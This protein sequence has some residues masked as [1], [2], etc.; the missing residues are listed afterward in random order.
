MLTEELLNMRMGKFTAS[1]S[2]ILFVGGKGATR[3]N[4]IIEKAIE[5]LTGYRKD[6]TSRHTDHGNFYEYDGIEATKRILGL[7][8]EWH[9]DQFIPYGDN[10]GF[11]PDCFEYDLDG[12][13]IATVDL[14]CPSTN[15]FNQK[16]M[17][18][19]ESKPEFQ[20]V[21]KQYYWQGQYQMLA[22]SN[23]LG[24]DVTKHRVIRYLPESVTDD[25]GNE[26][27][28]FTIP[29]SVRIFSATIERNEDDQQRLIEAIE[30]AVI[31]RD[32][33]V[34]ILETPI[35]NKK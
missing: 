23:H 18:V 33:Y 8:V 9:W 31:E 35:I 1:S 32:M 14:K 21:P 34:K 19:E 4:Y 22:L 7:L 15:F 3:T 13:V 25:E 24:Y 29:E 16:I 26:L 2:H 5:K 17:F 20:N 28:K 30:S 12:K 11:T 10:G 27:H 6:F